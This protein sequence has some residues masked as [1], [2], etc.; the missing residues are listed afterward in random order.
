[1][2]DIVRGTQAVTLKWALGSS[3][4]FEGVNFISFTK[5]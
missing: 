2:F 1:M 5:G 3:I 4:D